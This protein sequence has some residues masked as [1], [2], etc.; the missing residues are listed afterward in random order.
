MVPRS[1]QYLSYV[2]GAAAISDD[3]L[4]D[5]GIELVASAA[6]GSRALLIPGGALHAYKAL[7]RERMEPGFWNEIVGR[8][9]IFF[10]FKLSDGTLKE[11]NYSLENQQSQQE[12][13]RL[14]SELNND[15]PEKTADILRYL[16]GNAFY[17]ALMVECYGVE[18]AV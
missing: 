9:E 1:N 16:A 4:R 15:P 3:E 2:M 6:S 10:I 13:A 5:R 12:I 11:L 7:V 14:C 17:R 18:I 8:A